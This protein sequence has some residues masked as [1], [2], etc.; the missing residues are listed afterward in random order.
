M[1]SGAGGTAGRSIARSYPP[2]ETTNYLLIGVPATVALA[3]IAIVANELRQ[4]RKD[5][6]LADHLTPLAPPGEPNN[7]G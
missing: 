3:V 2:A 7:D 1:S 4:R 6:A 5:K